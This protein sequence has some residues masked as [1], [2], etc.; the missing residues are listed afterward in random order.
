M[1][2]LINIAT[3]IMMAICFVMVLPVVYMMYI[4][5][6]KAPNREKY[7][8]NNNRLKADAENRIFEQCIGIKDSTQQELAKSLVACSVAYRLL[9]DLLGENIAAQ[10]EAEA[11]IQE[12]YL[13]MVAG[14]FNGLF[15]KRIGLYKEIN[16]IIDDEWKPNWKKIKQ[17]EKSVNIHSMDKVL[18]DAYNELPNGEKQIQE[19]KRWRRSVHRRLNAEELR[20]FIQMQKIILG[21]SALLAVGMFSI[22]SN[23]AKANQLG[24]SS[25]DMIWVNRETGEQFDYDP[26][27]D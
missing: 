20:K 7:V 1:M 21:G 5:F 14:I 4:T 22:A 18:I 19:I 23:A 6:F 11:E 27:N 8:E 3:F 10:N 17:L 26:R 13:T 15:A 24:S 12:G 16:R 25:S 9:G 2:V